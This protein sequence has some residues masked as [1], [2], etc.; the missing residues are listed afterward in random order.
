M[1]APS[2]ESQDHPDAKK[3]SKKFKRSLD[4]PEAAGRS[5]AFFKSIRK[6]WL[7]HEG[8]WL[9][10]GAVYEIDDQRIEN[11]ISRIVAGLT[12]Y[13]KSKKLP[14]SYTVTVLGSYDDRFSIER[15]QKIMLQVHSMEPKKTIGNNVFKYWRA[16]SAEE[17]D[18]TSVWVFQFYEGAFFIGIVAE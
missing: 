10:P 12:W 18:Y 16:L 13:E 5:K 15:I 11:V 14:E 9:E 1:L 3:V 8:G 4:R 2:W 6:V 7:E 17:E